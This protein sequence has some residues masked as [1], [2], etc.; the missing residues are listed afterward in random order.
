MKRNKGTPLWKALFFERR[1]PWRYKRYRKQIFEEMLRLPQN[2]ILMPYRLQNLFKEDRLKIVLINW[3]KITVPPIGKGGIEILLWD[4]RNHLIK[5]GH[6]IKIYNTQDTD[7][8]KEEIKKEDYDFIHLHWIKYLPFL[9]FLESK[10]F[11]VTPHDGNILR[12]DVIPRSLL[13]SLINTNKYLFCITDRT[14]NKLIKYGA[15]PKKIFV[16]KN[17]VNPNLIRWKRKPKYEDRSVYIG[18]ITKGKRQFKYIEYDLNI[19]F[20]GDSDYKLG[21]LNINESNRNLGEWNKKKLYRNLTNYAN[22][23][24]LSAYEIQPLVCLEALSAGLG[25][26]ISEA[27]SANLDTSKDFIDVIPEDKIED[28][29]YIRKIIEKNREISLK[30]RK[31]IRKY[32]IENFNLKDIVDKYERIIQSVLKNETK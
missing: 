22:L 17:G 11:A 18:R 26:V 20:V 7:W 27:A 28:I 15:D 31:E 23:V 10:N 21:S 14:K 24:L 13:D 5:K 2:I 16:I 8:L 9:E 4:Y 1:L 32:A 25:L 29:G 30:K 12:E 3:G 6:K 19:D